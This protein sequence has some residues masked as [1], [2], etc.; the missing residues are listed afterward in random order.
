[1]IF[2]GLHP[3]LVRVNEYEIESPLQ[4]HLLF[5]WHADQP[6]VIGTLGEILGRLGINISRMQVG[7]S[8][9]MQLAIAILGISEGL[10]SKTVET[11]EEIE[12]VSRALQV[13]V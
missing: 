5:T 8:D 3:R 13:E 9:N 7:V 4:G 11:I 12:A 1:M 10:D 2:D 6:G